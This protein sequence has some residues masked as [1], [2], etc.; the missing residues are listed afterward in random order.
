MDKEFNLVAAIRIL[1]KWKMPIAIITIV[2]GI[3][4]AFFSFFIMDE[5]F[6]SWSTFYPVNQ[7]L[8]DRVHIFNSES[9]AGQIDYFG[10]KGDVNRVLTIANSEPVIN[11]IIDSFK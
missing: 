9:S 4:A 3:A 8:T 11:Y 6:L 2:A 10:N 1:L 5:Y 7:Y